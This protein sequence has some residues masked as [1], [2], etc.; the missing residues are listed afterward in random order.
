MHYTMYGFSRGFRRFREGG[1]TMNGKLFMLLIGLVL[2]A[3]GMFVL[4]GGMTQVKAACPGP[5][6]TPCGNGDVN[7]SGDT[8][9]ADAVYLLSYLFASGVAPVAIECDSCCPPVCP[10]QR[11]PATG[12]TKCYDL[13]GYEIEC[14]SAD[15]PGQD[16]FSQKGCPIASRFV[17]N[18]DGTLTDSCTGLMWQKTTADVNGDGQ[19]NT[20]LH[21]AD[22][23]SWEEALQYCESLELGGHDDWRLPNVRELESIVDYGRCYPSID[24]IF[25]LE[26]G[27]YWSSTT[28]VNLQALAWYVPFYYGGANFDEKRFNFNIRAVR[29]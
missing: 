17:D 2:G 11:L 16:G 27:T 14:A 24:P 10:P 22:S 15:Y 13:Q 18:G 28:V 21:G 6:G 19:V 23:V 5:A 3:A 1:S 12:Q 8:D 26:Y 29:G 20:E 25:G 4:M 7:G 9:I